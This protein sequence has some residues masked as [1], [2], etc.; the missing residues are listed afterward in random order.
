M[1]LPVYLLLVCATASLFSLTMTR[2]PI[3]LHA[4]ITR[5]NCERIRRGMPLSDVEGILGQPARTIWDHRE[6][7]PP[8]S[9]TRWVSW[10]GRWTSEEAEITVWFD[11]HGK[12]N[13]GYWESPPKSGNLMLIKPDDPSLLAQLRSWLGW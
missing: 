4:A 3:L 2:Q 5:V 9:D 7:V 8:G 6:Y 12:V 11:Y 13:G 1:R 10:L